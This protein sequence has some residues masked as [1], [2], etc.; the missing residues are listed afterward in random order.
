MCFL[1]FL[2]TGF[3]VVIKDNCLYFF[4]CAT[5]LTGKINREMKQD[6]ALMII[7]ASVLLWP[8]GLVSISQRHFF[9][10]DGGRLQGD[11]I[12]TGVSVDLP[13]GREAESQRGRPGGGGLA[14]GSQRHVLVQQ[15]SQGVLSE[16]RRLPWTWRD[17]ESSALPSSR[18]QLKVRKTFR[19]LRYI[20]YLNLN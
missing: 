15:L 18:R 2:K 6:E 8:A 9:E 20:V 10:D 4:V 14:S 1:R 11:S 19:A 13:E 17:K 16:H 12:L 7:T 5:C 3:N